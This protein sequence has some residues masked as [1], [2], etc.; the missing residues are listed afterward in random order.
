MIALRQLSR[1]W[2]RSSV[3]RT[4]GDPRRV[5]RPG[6]SA[7]GLRVLP[8]HDRRLEGVPERPDVDD[9]E[10]PS[11]DATARST[12]A[13]SCAISS[14]YMVSADSSGASS[15]SRLLAGSRSSWTRRAN[16]T[17]IPQLA[18]R[19]P[20][21]SGDGILW[22]RM[23]DD[24]PRLVAAVVAVTLL[25]RITACAAPGGGR[26][27]VT[28]PD[29]ARVRMVEEQIAG[30]GITDPAVLQAMRTVPRHEF[31]PPQSR[32]DAY[33]D[34]PLPIGHGQTISQP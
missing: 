7:R 19:V 5:R 29:A 25:G 2:N 22:R 24:L 10:H 34:W 17:A 12:C 1:G 14:S 28:A 4:S 8:Q 33:A 31:V 32:A 27:G 11:P 3:S 15:A 30:R 13:E 6:T 9:G 23:A 16:V 20:W 18:C 21:G 26:S